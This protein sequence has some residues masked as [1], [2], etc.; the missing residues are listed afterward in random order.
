MKLLDDLA[1]RIGKTYQKGEVVFRQG[2]RGDTMFVVHTGAV[3]IVRE[4]GGASSVINKL[5]PGEFFGEMALVD[6][7]PRSATVVAAER[8]L[9]VPITRDFV[10]K[11]TQKDTKFIF[12]ILES[13]CHRLEAT[14]KLIREKYA[15]RPEP[16]I[17]LVSKDEYQEPRSAA[18]LKSVG[19]AAQ[20]GSYVK[21][22]AGAE[23]FKRGVPGDRMFIILEGK[24]QVV[25]EERQKRYVL[26]EL[27]RGSFFGELALITG[28][29][30]TATVVA[31]EPVTLLPLDRQAF[32]DRIRNDPEV[33]LHLVQILILRL[34]RSLRAVG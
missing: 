19:G 3:E 9:L 8:S 15:N 5:G 20:A 27:G 28:Q 14:N 25:Q 7:E 29:A 24:V 32:L 6:L 4:K 18:F 21:I 23:V 2:D 22:E 10:F 31:A 16:V 1:N 17:A 26:V 13:L 33:A 12:S 34:R 30:R 11:H